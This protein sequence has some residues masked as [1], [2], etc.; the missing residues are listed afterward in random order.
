ME[1]GKLPTYAHSYGDGLFDARAE[2]LFADIDKQLNRWNNKYGSKNL[3]AA[4]EN[5][6]SIGRN[7]HAA[8]AA[9]CPNTK[10]KSLWRNQRAAESSS[11]HT[12]GSSN[13]NSS[14]SCGCNDSTPNS[15]STEE[16]KREV[17]ALGARVN[18]LEGQLRV[19]DS[20]RTALLKRLEFTQQQML[21]LFDAHMTLQS[22][23]VAFRTQTLSLSPCDEAQEMI[24]GENSYLAAEHLT[25]TRYCSGDTCLGSSSVASTELV[26]LHAVATVPGPNVDDKALGAGL[27]PTAPLQKSTAQERKMVL[28]QLALRLYAPAPS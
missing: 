21:K 26:P 16:L 20:E 22:E 8:E 27:R 3:H 7:T 17:S 25:P 6:R 4:L 18:D 12:N 11:T 1:R 24:R 23:W 2:R 19:A 14:C 10:C 28:E 13:S 5:S 15:H 9:V